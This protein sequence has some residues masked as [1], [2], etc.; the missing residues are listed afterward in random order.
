MA[1]VWN[2]F[3]SNLEF[4]L[5][6]DPLF[7]R[8]WRRYVDD[9]IVII[10]KDNIENLKDKLTYNIIYNTIKF[11]IEEEN[12]NKIPFLDLLLTRNQGQIYISIY[13]KPTSTERYIPFSSNTSININ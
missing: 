8:F 11:T 7:Q 3:M 6:D 12:N 13:R 10:K 1:L 2:I 4:S 5:K 9:I